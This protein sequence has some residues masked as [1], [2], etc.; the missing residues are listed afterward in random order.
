M[1]EMSGMDIIMTTQAWC[2]VAFK[3]LEY[4]ESYYRSLELP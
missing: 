3:G 1:M 4:E 2:R